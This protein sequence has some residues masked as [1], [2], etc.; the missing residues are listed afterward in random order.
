MKKVCPLNYI[1]ER[2]FFMIFTVMDNNLFIQFPF[3]PCKLM[4]FYSVLKLKSYFFNHFSFIQKKYQIL[5]VFKYWFGKG[6]LTF[7]MIT[8]S[9]V[10]LH[11]YGTRQNRFWNIF[12]CIPV[13]PRK[14]YFFINFF[15]RGILGIIFNL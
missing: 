3:I 2:T 8:I 7:R 11:L 13:I 14:K 10:K 6:Y 15:F 5:L 4:N 1:A 12:F 9:T